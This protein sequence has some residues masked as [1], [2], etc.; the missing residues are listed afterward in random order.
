MIKML[1]GNHGVVENGKVVA[2]DKYSDPFEVSQ[3]KEAELIASGFAKKVDAPK[4]AVPKKDDTKKPAEAKPADTKTASKTEPK[5]NDKSK[6]VK[7][8]VK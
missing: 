2:K 1:K 4:N 7:K 5:P 8:D 6:D 3:E